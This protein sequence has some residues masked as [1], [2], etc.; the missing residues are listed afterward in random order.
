LREEEEGRRRTEKGE[1]ERKGEGRR[2]EGE[3]GG[4]ERGSLTSHKTALG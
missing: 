4:K 2:E 1:G 3:R